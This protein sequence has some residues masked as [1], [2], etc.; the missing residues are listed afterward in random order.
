MADTGHADTAISILQRR[1]EQVPAEQ[2][3]WKPFALDLV[4][5]V[6]L[7]RGGGMANH[8]WQGVATVLVDDYF[9]EIS[10]AIF[11]AHARRDKTKSWFMEH[12]SAVVD[13]LLACAKRGSGRVWKH[14]QHYLA[15]PGG[16]YL[17]AIGFP[18]AVM[19]L[20]P[21][22]EV[23]AWVAELPIAKVAE[24]VAPLTRMSNVGNLADDTLAARLIGEYGDD[25]MV[26]DAFFSRYVSSS[27]WGPASSH[28]SDL[29]EALTHVADCTA[30]AKLRDWAS[31][32]ARKISEMAE[33]EQQREQEQELLLR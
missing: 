17:F 16:A 4:T 8:Y 20:L 21:V 14:L 7:I 23:L 28:W 13:V 26:A 3:R 22:G 19:D 27:W 1:I 5:N 6:D 18:S 15:L 30:V 2:E 12:E 31:A 24:R 33:Q 10:A 29:A 32:T 11:E 9:E 25:P